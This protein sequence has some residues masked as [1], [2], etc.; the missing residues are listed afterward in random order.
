MQ[1][2]FPEGDVASAS[3][4]VLYSCEAFYNL[5]KEDEKLH[6]GVVLMNRMIRLIPII[7]TLM[8]L[9]G[10]CSTLRTNK[11]TESV[12]T[13]LNNQPYQIRVRSGHSIM[14]RII[15]ETAAPEFSRHI[16]ISD[17][18]SYRGIIEIIYAGLSDS[19]FL[20]ATSDFATGSVLGN[21]WYTGTG[22]IGLS[23]SG[24]ARDTGSGS[25]AA[26]T[27]M[28]EDNTMRITIKSSQEEQ[29]WT[30]DYKHKS[31]YSSNNEQKALKRA[32]K[33]IVEQLQND[34][35]AIAR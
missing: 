8:A 22:Y 33:K 3:V 13:L 5:I 1:K 4:R 21:A 12:S 18:G 9:V 34:F 30:A 31:V 11:N 27:A 6:K 23:G 28:P 29:L 15:Y 10:G 2:E 19:S 24:T 16:A 14:D 32:M 7:V 17:K 35:P 20:D 25:T 26:R